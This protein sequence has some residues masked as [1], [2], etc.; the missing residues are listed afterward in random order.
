MTRASGKC[1]F[2]WSV[3][4]M[5]INNVVQYFGSVSKDTKV[6]IVHFYLF[7]LFIHFV[8]IICS[9]KPVV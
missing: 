9:G 1:G 6:Y 7:C 4:P 2:T 8:I 5:S 3:L